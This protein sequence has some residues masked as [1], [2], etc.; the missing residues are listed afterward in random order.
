MQ[1]V[2][3]VVKVYRNGLEPSIISVACI[4]HIPLIR[5]ERGRLVEERGSEK[6]IYVYLGDLEAVAED[7]GD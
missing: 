4:I 1:H 5:Q 3:A 6:H 2:A 7:L